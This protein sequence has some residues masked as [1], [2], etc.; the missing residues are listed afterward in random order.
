MLERTHERGNRLLYV[1]RALC[2]FCPAGSAVSW[3]RQGCNWQSMQRVQNTSSF[4]T[5]LCLN[6]RTQM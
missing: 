1:Y 3:N 6:A 5:G 2:M 4:G